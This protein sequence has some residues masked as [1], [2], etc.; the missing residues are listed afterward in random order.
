MSMTFKELRD[1]VKRRTTRDQGGTQFDTPVKN[2]IN[3]SLFRIARESLWKPLR[4]K[5]TFDTVIKY[6][7]GSGGGTFTNGSKSITMVGATF[8]TDGIAIGRRITLQGSSTD[9]TIVTITGETTLTL[10]ISYNGTTINGTGTYSI[11]AQEEYNLPIQA[12]SRCFMWHEAYGYPRMVGYVTDQSFYASGITNTSSSIVTHYRMW[13]EDT[14][15][16]QPLEASV[17]TVVSSST[18]DTSISVTVFG[19]VA[20]YPDFETILVNGTSSVVGT[21]SFTSIDRVAKA[22]S[23]IGRITVTAN[24]GNSTLAVLPVGDITSSVKYSKVQ[25]YPLPSKVHPINVQYYKEIYRL[26]NDGDIHELGQDFDEA[27]ILLSSAKINLE[28]NK[29][30]G[31]SFMA[32][33]KDEVR[34]L[35]KVN[36]DKI[37]FFPT[38]KRGGAANADTRIHANLLFQQVG[39]NYGPRSR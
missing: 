18:S 26:V 35:R 30:E 2:I 33:Y 24:S 29:D 37:D 20:G 10:D 38:L 23:T 8:I 7:T 6:T 27:I 13:G 9:Y 21:K 28:N 22:N 16:S 32:L 15:I 39:P 36:V 5:T 34:T 25:L 14:V 3:T 31:S 17:I 12:N 4:R 1:E 19:I 11:L